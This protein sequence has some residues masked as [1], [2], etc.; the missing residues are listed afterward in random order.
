MT[1]LLEA[2]ADHWG[3][4]GCTR[5]EYDDVFRF[6][7]DHGDAYAVWSPGQIARLAEP[8]GRPFNK[9]V[10]KSQVIV[11]GLSDAP[12]CW[13]TVNLDGSY[14]SLSGVAGQL[15]LKVV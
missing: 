5:C 12:D 9:A 11:R 10:L 3:G 13:W 8:D 15:Q 4:D 14:I 2:I 7:D 6:H 1:P